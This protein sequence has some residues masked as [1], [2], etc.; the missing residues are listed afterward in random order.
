MNPPPDERYRTTGP[1]SSTGPVKCGSA[2][3][4]VVIFVEENC[5]ACDRVVATARELR[6]IGAIGILNIRNRNNDASACEALGVFVYPST[7]VNGRLT[8][9]GEFSP[10]EFLN[11]YPA[12]NSNYGDPERMNPII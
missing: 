11:L 5:A 9:H 4:E 1:V 8:F 2:D 6:R 12:S 7:Y 3:I 10:G